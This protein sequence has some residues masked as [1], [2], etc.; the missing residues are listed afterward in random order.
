MFLKC[1]AARRAVLNRTT[2]PDFPR[3]DENREN[4]A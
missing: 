1:L 2:S 4:A 3:A